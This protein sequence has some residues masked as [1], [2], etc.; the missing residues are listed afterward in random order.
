M[1]KVLIKG[2]R[3][4]DEMRRQL[5]LSAAEASFADQSESFNKTQTTIASAILFVATDKFGLHRLTDQRKKGGTL[6][7]VLGLLPTITHYPVKIGDINLRIALGAETPVPFVVFNDPQY[8][9]SQL[10]EKLREEIIDFAES[11]EE[12]V[13]QVNEAEAKIYKFIKQFSS[14]KMLVAASPDFAEY[15]PSD[16]LEEAE[17]AAD[18]KSLADILAR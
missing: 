4:K 9:Y 8:F 7:N 6:V 12:Y 3:F 16:W 1:K 17:V 5:A 14:P 18:A 11:S 10:P 15:L 13:A 2:L